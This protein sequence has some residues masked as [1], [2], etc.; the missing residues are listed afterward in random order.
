MNL[1]NTRKLFS[2]IALYPLT[3]RSRMPLQ[4][5]EDLVARARQEAENPSLKAYFPLYVDESSPRY[6]ASSD[7]PDTLLSDENLE[8]S[9]L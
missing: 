5:F 6:R 4:D 9:R 1:E 7:K 8:E 2:S 3:Q